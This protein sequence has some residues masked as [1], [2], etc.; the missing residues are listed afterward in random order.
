LSRRRPQARQITK[1]QNFPAVRGA[2][3]TAD[4]VAAIASSLARTSTEVAP[5]RP[6]PRGTFERMV[7]FGPGVPLVPAP[8]NPVDPVTAR[9]LPRQWEY[10][11]AW[12]LPGFGERLIPWKVLRDAAN[13]ITLFRRCIEIRKDEVATLDWDVAISAKAIERAQRQD[14]N[15]AKKDIEKAMRERVDPHIGRLVDFWDL[16]DSRSGLDF[17]G[18][19]GKVLEE[20]FV[21]D[22][23]AI[24]PRLSRGGDLLAF[25]VLDG[26]TIKPLL[27]NYG[28][29]PA[30]PLP[31]FQQVLY[32][33]PRGEFVADGV[34]D[35]DNPDQLIVSDAYPSDRLVYK[36]HN[37]RTWT[38][39]GFSAVE[40][41]LSDGELF[42][43][44]MGWLRAEYTEGTMPAGW[45]ETDPMQGE[46]SPAMLRE[47]ETD[48]NN[49]FA[50]NTAARQRHRILPPGMKAVEST[51]LNERYRPD[52]DLHLIKLVASH[53][54]TTIA[55]LGF[56]EA[57][58][59]GSTGWHEGQADVQ[60][61]KATQ[62]TLRRLQALCT[63]L[64][65]TYLNAPPELEFKILGLESED[66]NAADEI[67]ERRINS[68]RMTRNE[69]RDRT[70][71]PRYAFPEADMPMVSTGRGVVFL[72]GASELGPP[73]TLIAPPQGPK[74]TGQP[75]EPGEPGGAT[76]PAAGAPTRP[77]A[78]VSKVDAAPVVD[79]LREDYPDRALDWLDDYDW[80]LKDVP[81]SQIDFSN[82]ANWQAAK[83][84]DKVALFAKKISKGKM[85]PVLLVRPKGDD[86]YIV[87]DG[88]HR[89]MAAQRLGIP[90]RAWTADV[91]SKTGP[92][93]E[94]HA[95]QFHGHQDLT[96]NTKAD[97]VR[98][99][100]A[101][102]RWLG[103]GKDRPFRFAVL[104]KAQATAAGVDL[105]KAEFSEAPP[106]G[107][108]KSSALAGVAAGPG[109]GRVLGRPARVGFDWGELRRQFG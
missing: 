31:A 86:K 75:G 49:W 62:P 95:Q 3:F 45:I 33:F 102:R 100:A 74:P 61:R 78:S 34:P 50:G 65:R 14:P 57:N 22:A 47:F 13:L 82:S 53:F 101:Y 39:Y 64:M 90:V 70:G 52:Y 25:E 1:A 103:K 44:R 92:W 26:S 4:Q 109:G 41:A 19:A 36:V 17:A 21:L 83:E 99:L 76:P 35:P 108:P 91:P 87:V 24:Y 30:P 7:P 106:L 56:T 104:T 77:A 37:V 71:L 107:Q 97:A 11:V 27:D 98:E 23:L 28:F 29:R 40:Q 8:I 55:E 54:S 46:W 51:A 60:D 88:H 67:A 6:L 89:S 85:K 20:Y 69:D 66:E 80:T 10:P 18:W 93:D 42:A 15:A 79:Q 63:G 58:G 59:L 2:S 72:E 48:F 94:M 16:P 84:P 38:P 43:R 9:P 96:E 73:G 32:G 5:A 105:S 68:G 12:N 81:L